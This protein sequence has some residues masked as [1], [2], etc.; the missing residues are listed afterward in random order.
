MENL[1]LAAYLLRTYTRGTNDCLDLAGTYSSER[2][3]EIMSLLV[4]RKVPKSMATC[5]GLTRA[6]CETAG[7][8]GDCQ[9]ERERNLKR[10]MT[11]QSVKI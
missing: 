1:Q 3:R 8:G 9:V 5:S 6:F 2:R 7:I 11:E 10:W 4:G